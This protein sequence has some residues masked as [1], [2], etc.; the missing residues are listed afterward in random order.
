L[1]RQVSIVFEPIPLITAA[2][3]KLAPAR[4]CPQI[5]FSSTSLSS[6]EESVDL[7]AEDFVD[8]LWLLAMT[9]LLIVVSGGGQLLVNDKGEWDGARLLE[10][11]FDGGV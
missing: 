11:V 7:S 5:L 10:G 3:A 2:S 6:N 1:P 9:L 4:G 8:E